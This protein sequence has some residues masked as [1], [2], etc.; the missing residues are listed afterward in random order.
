MMQAGGD[1][2]RL[3]RRDVGA[4][5]DFSTFFVDES[6]RLF[7]AL[8]FVTGNKADAAEIMQDAFLKLWERW[9]SIDRIDDHA[10]HAPQACRIRPLEY[11]PSFSPDGQTV[12]FQRPEAN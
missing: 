5:R 4:P 9:D 1:V 10:A 6:P 12:L 8:Y 7:E 2:A 3:Q 11:G